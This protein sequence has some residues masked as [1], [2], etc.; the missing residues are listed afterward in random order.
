VYSPYPAIQSYLSK[1][2]DGERCSFITRASRC[3]DALTFNRIVGRYDELTDF[4]QGV[5]TEVNSRLAAWQYENADMLDSVFDSYSING[6]SAR[7]G[8]N[9]VT[10]E[11]G[12]A[13]P[14]ELYRLI[15][16]TGL[17]CRSFRY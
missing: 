15:Q 11:N 2:P 8:G 14:T 5:I 6:V 10:V 16:Q 12:V 7:F 4:Q 17:C 3:I 1:I 13:L 9:G